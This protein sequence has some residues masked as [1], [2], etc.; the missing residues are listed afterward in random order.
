PTDD[1]VGGLA[2]DMSDDEKRGTPG[3][4]TGGGPTGTPSVG[5]A[6]AGPVPRPRRAHPVSDRDRARVPERT[7]PEA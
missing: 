7:D 1:A 5:D 2:D 3:G 6:P 4:G